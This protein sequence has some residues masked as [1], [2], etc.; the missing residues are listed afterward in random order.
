MAKLISTNPAQGYKEVG[1]V[2]ISSQ[3]DVDLA[4][5]NAR[6]ALPA[7]RALSTKERGEY[8]YEFLKLYKN[9]VEEL[10]ELQTKEMGKPITESLSECSSRGA[11]LEL[12]IERSIRVLEPQVLDVYDTY[13]TELHFEPYGVV[14]VILPRSF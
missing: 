11:A 3:V 6:K 5:Q 14:A 13:Q 10:A 9:R 2:T 8:F 1:S 7:W 4:V 12:N